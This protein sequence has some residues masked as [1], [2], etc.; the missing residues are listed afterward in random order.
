MNAKLLAQ[1][2]ENLTPLDTEELYCNM[3]DECYPDCEI[4]G[5]KFTTSR[6]LRELDPTAYRCGEN[7][8]IDSLSLIEISGDYYEQD[9]VETER[10]SL[11]TD[12]EMEMDELKGDIDLINDDIQDETFTLEDGEAQIREV[13]EK[14]DALTAEIEEIKEYTF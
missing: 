2:T 9:A 1:I 13:Q 7:D 14:I 6:A 4:A 11:V 5:M 10:D 3:L 12:L 8:Y